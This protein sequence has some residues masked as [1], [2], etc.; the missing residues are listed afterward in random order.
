MTSPLQTV[1][2][3]VNNIKLKLPLFRLIRDNINENVDKSSQIMDVMAQNRPLFSVMNAA[4]SI[5][6]KQTWCCLYLLTQFGT[7]S[8]RIYWQSI[9]ISSG[10]F[11]KRLFSRVALNLSTISALIALRE[12]GRFVDFFWIPLFLVLLLTLTNWRHHCS[13][14]FGMRISS[15]DTLYPTKLWSAFKK[16]DSM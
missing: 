7:E 10:F 5:Q 12:S 13:F 2:K 15:W 11:N 16:I 9:R 14:H 6:T 8:L 1:N 4:V 3:N